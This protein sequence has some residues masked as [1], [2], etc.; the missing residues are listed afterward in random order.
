[1]L[2]T[3]LPVP[4]S[5]PDQYILVPGDLCLPMPRSIGRRPFQMWV[6]EVNKFW[7]RWIFHTNEFAHILGTWGTLFTHPITG[8]MAW[9]CICI[10][11]ARSLLWTRPEVVSMNRSG[12]LSFLPDS[13]SSLGSLYCWSFCWPSF[14]LF[15]GVVTC[16]DR[17]IHSSCWQIVYY[18]VS[19]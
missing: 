7:W 9:S 19:T 4:L 5:P 11:K 2:L 18:T 14:E 16:A 8:H 6:K 17:K 13:S 10:W 12:E 3:C 1:M 15:F